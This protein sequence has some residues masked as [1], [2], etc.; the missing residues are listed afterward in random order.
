MGEEK[1]RKGTGGTAGHR[2][3]ARAGGGGGWRRGLR[4]A[5][6]LGYGGAS[7]SER[8]DSPPCLRPHSHNTGNLARSRE[9][10]PA[11]PPHPPASPRPVAAPPAGGARGG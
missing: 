9:E 8:G 5:P 1:R 6:Y 2:R 4:G 10:K 11:E 7:A 3:G